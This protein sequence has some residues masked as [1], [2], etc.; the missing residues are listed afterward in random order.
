MGEWIAARRAYWASDRLAKT[1]CY[2]LSTSAVVSHR[3]RDVLMIAIA[4]CL[5]GTVGQRGR[6]ASATWTI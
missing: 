2:V 5:D 6:I 4:S 3:G 1:P